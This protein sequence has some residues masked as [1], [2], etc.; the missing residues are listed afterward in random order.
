[1]IEG[2]DLLI[3]ESVM[4]GEIDAIEKATLNDCIKLRDRWMQ[5]NANYQSH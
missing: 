5:D 1:L 4:T 3:D 2:N